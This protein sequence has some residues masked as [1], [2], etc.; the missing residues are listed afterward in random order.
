MASQEINDLN[1][2]LDAYAELPSLNP[3][4]HG[5]FAGVK[6]QTR[7]PAKGEKFLRSGLIPLRG[8]SRNYRDNVDEEG[9]SCYRVI[10]GKLVKASPF[11]PGFDGG[12]D[13]FWITGQVIQV[14]TGD[15]WKD[16]C[17]ADREPLIYAARYVSRCRKAPA[18]MA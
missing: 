10:G 15:G 13:L 12:N 4:D 6:I 3:R 2:E 9:V 14:D 1:A 16:L 5:Y 8:Y 11:S 17:G 7:E 18:E